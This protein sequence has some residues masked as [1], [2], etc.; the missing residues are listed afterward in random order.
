[1]FSMV[2]FSEKHVAI[3]ALYAFDLAVRDSQKTSFTKKTTD[4]QALFLFYF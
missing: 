2:N 3:L 4:V 1:M